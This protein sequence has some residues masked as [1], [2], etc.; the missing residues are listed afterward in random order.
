MQHLHKT[1]VPLLQ[2]KVFVLSDLPSS[3]SH[4]GTRHSSLATVPVAS[5]TI[6]I[7]CSGDHDGIVWGWRTERVGEEG[8]GGRAAAAGAVADAEVAGAA[9]R[10]CAAFRR[11]EM[12]LQDFG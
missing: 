12:G 5:V 7:Q 9:L 2:A 3:V 4:S 11:G 10:R 8:Q 1:G 6:R